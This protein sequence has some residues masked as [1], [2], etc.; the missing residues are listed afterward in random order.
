M[1]DVYV[2]VCV[3][4]SVHLYNEHQSAATLTARTVATK[5]IVRVSAV[6]GARHPRRHLSL[7]APA[8]P[9]RA[10]ADAARSSAMARRPSTRAA[11]WGGAGAGETYAV[12]T[13]LWKLYS[14]GTPR[15]G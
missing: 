14:E 7:C 6:V 12:N 13:P 2:C 4:A 11:D 5:R 10:A 1:Y 3:R 15:A 8:A 9:Y